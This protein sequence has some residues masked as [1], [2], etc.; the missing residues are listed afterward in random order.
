MY[1]Y[2]ALAKNETPRSLDYNGNLSENLQIFQGDTK[3]LQHT[4]SL[5]LLDQNFTAHRMVISDW[6][7]LI[8]SRTYKVRKFGPTSKKSVKTDI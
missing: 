2:I 8:T 7:V 5:Y 4:T 3:L 1:I 6:A